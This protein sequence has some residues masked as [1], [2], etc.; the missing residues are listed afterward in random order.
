MRWLLASLLCLL[1]WTACL[2]AETTPTPASSGAPASI[3]EDAVKLLEL[4]KLCLGRNNP[5]FAA[6]AVKLDPDTRNAE[7]E[8]ALRTFQS[9]V[10][11]YPQY[12]D[13]WMWLGLALTETLQC[14]KEHPDGVPLLTETRI[15]DG[16]AA[17]QK[18]YTAN[19]SNLTYVCCLS[20]AL[21]LHRKDF[22]GARKLWD[23][24]LTTATTDVN[25]VTALVQAG[26]ACLNKAYFGK[27]ANMAADEVAKY[28]Q[29]AVTYIK[30]AARLL[31]KSDS[32]KE[33]QELLRQYRK[34][35][36]GK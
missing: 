20:D 25:R 26:R 31:P 8:K 1:T 14:S 36:T 4:G 35:L 13:G 9:L 3:T 29:A 6:T 16:L 24:Y 28:Y 11:R 27:S 2:A 15:S 30:Q 23:R 10:K 19:P 18:A 34:P 17:F 33:M 7:G 5:E 22:D 12:A 32:V 21:M